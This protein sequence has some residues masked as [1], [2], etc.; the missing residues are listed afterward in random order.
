MSEIQTEIKAIKEALSNAKTEIKTHFAKSIPI[1]K[2]EFKV[3]W[4]DAWDEYK[5]LWASTKAE[6]EAEQFQKDI[7]S[8]AIQAQ[9]EID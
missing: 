4:K 6:L 7:N 9:L 2:Q 5:V 8:L 1:A 3:L